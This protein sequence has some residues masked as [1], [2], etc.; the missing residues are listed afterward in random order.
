MK[1][2]VIIAILIGLVMG[3][4]ITYGYYHSKKTIEPNQTS[5]IATADDLNSVVAPENGKLSILSPED[6]TVQ[7]AKSVKVAGNTTP[8]AYVVIFVNDLPSITQADETGNFSKEVALNSL[9]NIITIHSI[10]STGETSVT[11]RSV[12]VYD[13]ELVQQTTP[14]SDNNESADEE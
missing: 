5:T 6:E 4:F 9:T 3:L 7:E 12:V 8:N 10:E 2:E 1:K 14:D 11:Q 13:Q